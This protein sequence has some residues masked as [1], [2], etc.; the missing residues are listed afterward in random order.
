MKKMHLG[1]FFAFFLALISCSNDDDDNGGT[2][3]PPTGVLTIYETAVS[4]DNLTILTE[5]MDRTKLDVPLNQPGTYTLFAPTDKAFTDAGFSFDDLSN[6]ELINLL[7]NHVL[8]TEVLSQDLSTGYITT[9]AK[10]P[11]NTNISMFVNT[12]EGIELNG[13]SI[14]L[15]NGMD[16]KA[17]NGVLHLV[18]TPIGIPD[19]GTHIVINRDFEAMEEVLV[20][21]GAELIEII[22][23]EGPFTIFVPSVEAFENLVSTIDPGNLTPESIASILAYHVI[24]G[25]NIRAEDL[26]DGQELTTANGEALKVDLTNGARLIDGT[27]GPGV[28]ITETNIQGS[29]GVIHMVE[30]VLLPPSLVDDLPD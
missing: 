8:D 6:E 16:T 9:L 23:G 13:T 1:F 4:S 30:K 27:E 20:N 29:N 17:S 7:L 19:V 2:T 26:T 22:Q 5:A 21:Y 24:I 12:E 28:P 18:D 10:G 25:E 14:P 15:V 3:P 11:E